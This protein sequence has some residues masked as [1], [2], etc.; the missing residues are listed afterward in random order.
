MALLHTFVHVR[1]ISAPA[2]VLGWLPYLREFV[3]ALSPARKGQKPVFSW[4]RLCLVRRLLLDAGLYARANEGRLRRRA[5]RTRKLKGRR[6]LRQL[7]H[8]TSHAI[9]AF[10]GDATFFRPLLSECRIALKHTANPHS[11]LNIPSE[12]R[13]HFGFV[14]HM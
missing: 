13:Q 3:F 7:Q 1:R 14:M 11:E 8:C 12:M 4:C 2:Y 6:N 10:Q 5:S 9:C